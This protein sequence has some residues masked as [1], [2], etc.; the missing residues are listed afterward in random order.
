MRKHTLIHADRS[1]KDHLFTFVEKVTG[2]RLCSKILRL[3]LGEPE[4]RRRAGGVSRCIH[5]DSLRES[6]S[7][8]MIFI[9]HMMIQLLLSHYHR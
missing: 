2:V 7:V 1:T 3:C 8:T 5:G 4:N 9:V 6:Q